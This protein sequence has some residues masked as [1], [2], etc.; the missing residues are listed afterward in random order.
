M[1]DCESKLVED[2]IRELVRGTRFPA[3]ASFIGKAMALGYRLMGKHRYD[4]FRLERILG[5]L[6]IVIPTVFNPKV[7][8]TG[9]FFAAHINSQRL[10]VSEEILDM[11]TGSGVCAVFAADFA[12]RVVAVDINAAAVRC[13]R[14]NA[15]LNDAES[16]IEVRQ[17]DLFMP[18]KGERFDLILFNP[19]F[20]R[21]APR[22]DRDSAWRSVDIA[23][24]FASGVRE[25]LKPRGYALVL[26]SSFGDSSI[27]LRELCR[28][29]FVLSVLAE[30]RF[31]NETLVIYKIE[32]NE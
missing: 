9:E 15:L 8:R 10:R 19:P 28:R 31:V 13:A 16:R 26:L 2:A 29:G 20:I 25:H 24:R 6:F 12:R 14:I 11:G 17:G 23:E 1:I 27:F 22:D 30:R 4:A 5:K 18:V 3:V 7:P 32:P 21:G